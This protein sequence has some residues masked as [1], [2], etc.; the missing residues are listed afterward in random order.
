M[1]TLTSDELQRLLD[2]YY[3]GEMPYDALTAIS[4]STLLAMQASDTD[5]DQ[6]FHIIREGYTKA[7]CAS[8]GGNKPS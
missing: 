3:E 6:L 4:V 1:Q 2:L 5:I 7:R 8:E